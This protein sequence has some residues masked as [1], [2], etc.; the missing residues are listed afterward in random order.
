M[1]ISGASLDGCVTFLNYLNR[2]DILI[3]GE[4]RTGELTAGGPLSRDIQRCPEVSGEIYPEISRDIS[5]RYISN[6]KFLEVFVQN[7]HIHQGLHRAKHLSMD[8]PSLLFKR[9]GSIGDLCML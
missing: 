8:L 9:G 7:Q 5:L 1:A 2:L 4:C 6:E 3:F